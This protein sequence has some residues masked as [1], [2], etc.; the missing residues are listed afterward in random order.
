MMLN[1]LNATRLLCCVLFTVFLMGC[2][3]IH[4]VKNRIFTTG[5]CI[6]G[7]EARTNTFGFYVDNKMYKIHSPSGIYG[8]I[9]YRDKFKVVYDSLDPEEAFPFINKP[10]IDSLESYEHGTAFVSMNKETYLPL[11]KETFIILNFLI[12]LRFLIK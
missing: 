5:Y 4:D 9:K 11:Y 1:K 3:T 8:L 7:I 6:N 12:K 10:V 2:F